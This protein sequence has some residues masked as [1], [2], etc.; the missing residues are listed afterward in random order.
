M[1]EGTE[2]GRL[3]DWMPLI[4]ALIAFIGVG[5][6][7]GLQKYLEARSERQK[8]LLELRLNAYRTFFG[9]QAKLQEARQLELAAPVALSPEQQQAAEKLQVE[10]RLAVKDAKFQIAVFG[11]KPV[12]ESLANYFRRYFP[13]ERCGGSAEMWRDDIQTYQ[14]MRREV[15]GDD[16]SQ[17][18][19]DA[20]LLLL[21]FNCQL[22]P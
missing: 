14:Q 17:R 5:M 12:V 4:T 22:N 15:F 9:G 3:K 1:S 2:S 21:L 11:T 16:A 8:N 20:T 18:I 10:Y 13:V 7:A 19:D 6:G